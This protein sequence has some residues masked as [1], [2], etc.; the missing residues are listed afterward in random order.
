MDRISRALELAS[1]QAARNPGPVPA[2]RVAAAAPRAVA[3]ELRPSAASVE[4]TAPHLAQILQLDRAHLDGENIL[5][6][7]ASGPH[8]G[9]YKLLR[10]QVL[11]RL[12]QLHANTLAVLSPDAAHG[13]TLTAINL[14]IAVA[15][16][17][18][19]TALLVD[20]NLRAPAVHRRLGFEPQAGVEDC[21]RGALPAEQ[22]IVRLAGYERLAVMP[23]KEAVENSSELLSSQRAVS[24]VDELRQRYFNRI[25][26]FDLPPVLPTDDA[27]AFSRLVQAGLL[28]VSDERTGREQL[29]RSL[30]LLGELP[31]IGTVLNDARD[32]RRQGA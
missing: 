1:A 12:D 32:A 10:T 24:L 20:L 26:I 14:A 13:N 16:E 29:R 2:P 25:V 8:G 30:A 7:N 21:L 17:L 4:M 22:V 28:V 19:R 5:P 11:Q 3:E 9:T 6:P 31:I 27:L 15:A 18:G 23:A